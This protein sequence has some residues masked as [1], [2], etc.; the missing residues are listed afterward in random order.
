MKSS[1]LFFGMLSAWRR[2]QIISS[3]AKD[4][5]INTKSAW[6]TK[7]VHKLINIHNSWIAGVL[8]RQLVSK[9][10]E[11]KT[12][13]RFSQSEEFFPLKENKYWIF[14]WEIHW[15][16]FT[17]ANHKSCPLPW[18]PRGLADQTRQWLALWVQNVKTCVSLYAL[19]LC[20][21]RTYIIHCT[22]HRILDFSKA[23][24]TQHKQIILYQFQKFRI[25]KNEVQEIG[26]LI[27][28]TVYSGSINKFKP[29]V[30]CPALW[31]ALDYI[32]TFLFNLR[33]HFA[34]R[35]NISNE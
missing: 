3:R 12:L 10:R 9:T 32:K 34:I 15:V 4:N 17:N 25:L 24:K 16:F 20:I 22:S 6:K 11:F 27:L 14:H 19:N 31:C 21:K 1:A 5:A 28:N 30:P 26:I 7:I 2:S 35:Q 33:S 13:S 23:F 18:D 29:Q 8:K